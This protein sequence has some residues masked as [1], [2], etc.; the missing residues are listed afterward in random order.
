V[1]NPSASIRIPVLIWARLIFDLRRRGARQRESGA[2]LLG[3]EGLHAKVTRYLC[4]DDLDP[5]AYQG[6][7]IAFHATG[8]A[9]LWKHCEQKNLQVLADVHT[10]GGLNV[11]QSAIDQRH[12]MLPRIGHTAMILPSFAYTKWWS[13]GLVGIYEYLGNFK[14]RTHPPLG[15]LRRVKLSLW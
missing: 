2:F 9:V 3:R 15:H 1:P 11:E 12:P 14:W 4:Y 13:L 10:H 5:N 7:A 6:G 8:Y